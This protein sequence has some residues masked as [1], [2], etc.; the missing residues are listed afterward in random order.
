MSINE[1]GR[2]FLEKTIDIKL[3][4]QPLEYSD[5]KLFQHFDSAVTK[6]GKI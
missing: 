6:K 4:Q 3:L 1:L 2:L 5:E